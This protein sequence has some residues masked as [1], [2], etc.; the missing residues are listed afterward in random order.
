MNTQS[1]EKEKQNGTFMNYKQAMEYMQKLQSLGSVPGLD[2][3]KRLCELLGNPQDELTFVHIAGTNGK[4]SVSAFLSYILMEA[5][6]RVGRYNSPTIRHYLERICV[7]KQKISQK[8]FAKIVTRVKLAC[9]SMVAE[10]LSQPTPFEVETAIGFCYFLEKK[11]DIVILEAGMGG[12]LDAT[13][14][15]KTTRLSILTSISMDHMAFLGDTLEKIAFEKSGII[16]EN[17]PVVCAQQRQ[18]AMD[19]IERVC[20]LNHAALTV[21]DTNRMSQ[22]RMGLKKQSFLLD[23]TLQIKIALLGKYQFENALVAITA[24]QRLKDLGMHITDGQLA[25]GMEKTVW[26]GRF[27][28]ISDNPLFFVDGAHNEDGARKLADSVRFYFTNKKIIYI[29]GILK[30]KQYEKII[31]HMVPMADSII[32]IKTPHNDRAMDAYE[33][34]KEV[35]HYHNNVT[36]ADSLLE[37]V[38]MAKLFADKN[39]VILAFGSLSFLGELM[40]IVKK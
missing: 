28:C 24:A 16:K 36:C 19:V 39:S 27:E 14:L 7:G 6:Y 3:I 15:I 4:G 1:V 30:D 8:S 10:G 20:L 13:N 40:D 35:M 23:E 25:R 34:A 12:R 9:D 5:G 22:I 2:S 31:Q 32:T 11:C 38:E 26:H 29:M 18:E 33:L 21:A 17:T 37:A